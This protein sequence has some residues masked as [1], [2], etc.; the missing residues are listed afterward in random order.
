MNFRI[1]SMW[2]KWDL[3]VHT[4]AS[5]LNNQ[6]GK[7]WD[8]YIYNLF[9]KAIN[10]KISVIG[11][12][13][14]Y[15]IAGYKKVLEYLNDDEKLK[16]IFKL[17]IEQDV[18]Y[19]DRIKRI[20]IIPNVELRIDQTVNVYLNGNNSKIQ[21]HV[22]LSNELSDIEIEEIFLHQLKFS[23]GEVEWPLTEYNIEKYGKKLKEE[24]G[25]GG[26]DSYRNIGY[27][28]VA[29]DVKNVYQLVHKNFKDKALIIGVEE[30]ITKINWNDQCGGI[31]RNI[32][33]MCD[34]IFSSNRKSIEWFAS[35]DAYNTIDTRK[36]CLWGS[37]AHE[38]S[39]LFKP[40]LDRYCWLK[41][42]ATFE[43]LK[44]AIDTINERVYIGE[45][46][47]ELKEFKKRASYSLK[48]IYI[49]KN[50]NSNSAKTWFNLDDPLILNPFMI[51]IIGNKGSGKSALADIIAYLS[52]SHKIGSASFLNRNRF[53]STNTKYGN[54]YTAKLSFYGNGSVVEKSFLDNSYKE[55]ESE[56]VQFLP[57]SYIEEVCND[58]GEKF[59][60]EINSVIFSYI[61]SE[62]K[63]DCNNLKELINKK[64]FSIEQKRQDYRN[65][66]ENL[67]HEIIILEEKMSTTYKNKISNALQV[68][69]DRLA[70]HESI[71]PIEVVKPTDLEQD[72]YS[73]MDIEISKE[74]Y[75]IE[76]QILEYKEKLRNI[77]ELIYKITQI[78]KQKDFV[79]E[80]C[81]SINITHDD[82]LKEMG[83]ESSN[84][85]IEVKIND[86][87]INNKLNDLTSQLNEINE[88]IIFNG[89]FSEIETINDDELVFAKIMQYVDM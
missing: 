87:I 58:L 35:D 3:H 43:G 52:N 11:I 74:I 56:K 62:N 38:F 30:D 15:S 46:P 36:A 10:E 23:D 5:I 41:C 81:N 66:I 61:P 4:P 73:T 72:T 6:F 7:D 39:K 40:D 63:L 1:G 42:D 34:A 86:V 85:F 33:K 24:K 70:N 83:I 71:K 67:N 51:S 79:L 55:E 29:V 54:D 8:K 14:Y 12:T 60:E 89:A 22:L 20:L 44:E 27:S 19:I 57:Q 59:Q 75:K 80:E 37:D 2:R 26:T 49:T 53:L 17:E 13:D 18:N 9:T 25:I 28:S 76:N 31:R 77:N 84:P 32:F 65:E 21:I 78:E 48:D 16:D 64:S 82:L 50:E 47:D 45:M 88:L 69:Q 68:Q